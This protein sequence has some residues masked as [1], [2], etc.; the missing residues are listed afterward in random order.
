MSIAEL[1]EIKINLITWI[2]QLSD[3]DLIFFLE[4]VRISTANS[5]WWEGL[6]TYQKKQ[7]L[8][9]LKDAHDGKVMESKEFWDNLNNA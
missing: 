8:A 1:N 5:D 9:G 4:G 7:V 3:H 6:S 2:N